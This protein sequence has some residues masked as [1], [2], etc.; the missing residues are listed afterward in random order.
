MRRPAL[1]IT[2]AVLAVLGL[3]FFLQGIGVLKGSSMSNTTFWSV[4]G[5]VIAAVGLALVAAG[6][7]NR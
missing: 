4:A 5:P 3:V 2:G 7:R 1:V 6:R